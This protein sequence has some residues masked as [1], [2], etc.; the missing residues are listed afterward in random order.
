MQSEALESGP[1]LVFFDLETTGLS[2][3][4]EIVQLAAVSSSH[5]LNLYVLP[6]GRMDWGAMRATGLSVH[7]HR[8]YLH[9]RPVLCTPP[10][11]ALLA[12]LSFLHMCQK[13]TQRPL[14][15]GHNARAF[16]VPVLLRAL[17]GRGLRG[18]LE[19]TVEG[20]VDSLALSRDM[21]RDRGV[22]SYRQEALV[23]R[24]LGEDY[25]AHDA[26][27]DARALQ[28]LVLLGLRPQL[29]D[30]SRHMFSLREMRT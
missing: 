29:E 16:D 7:K 28:R 6:Q 27:Q 23:R 17:E 11:E 30:L 10:T 26:L 3:D 22:C 8:L 4:S 2:R 5:S 24:L 18:A 21:L 1:P 19:D 15:V 25:T 12:F 20:A 13:P 14:L 9:K